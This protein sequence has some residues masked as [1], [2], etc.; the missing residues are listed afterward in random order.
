M[1]AY[2][3]VYDCFSK[4]IFKKSNN[5]VSLIIRSFLL[6][7]FNKRDLLMHFPVWSDRNT[8]VNVCGKDSRCSKELLIVR[9]Q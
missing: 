7:G 1:T 3:M 5:F 9:N 2:R 4:L 8:K 6:S